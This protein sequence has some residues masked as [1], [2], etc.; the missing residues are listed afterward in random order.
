MMK[1]IS[2]S[3]LSAA[4]TATS[5]I[6]AQCDKS[7]AQDVQSMI[8]EFAQWRIEGDHLA[9]QWIYAI[10][11]QPEA[12]RLQMVETYANMDACLFEGAREI[13]FYRKDKLMA[14]ATPTAVIRLIK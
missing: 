5:A 12:K 2:A 3:F 4:I 7:A 11:K 10:E 13:H 6:A 9:V 8:H 14:I 1:L